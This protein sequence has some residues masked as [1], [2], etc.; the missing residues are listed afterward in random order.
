MRN[1]FGYVAD[2]LHH[3]SQHI[4]YINGYRNRGPEYQEGSPTKGPGDDVSPQELHSNMRGTRGLF[5][6]YYDGK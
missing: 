5:E 3:H 1:P 6:Q 2:E 4:D